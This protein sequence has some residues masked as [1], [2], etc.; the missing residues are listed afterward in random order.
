[1]ESAHWRP[2]KD[3]DLEDANKYFERTK[4]CNITNLG[5]LVDSI[6]ISQNFV[7]V[8]RCVIDSE[9]AE[10][11]VSARVIQAVSYARESSAQ[12]CVNHHREARTSIREIRGANGDPQVAQR[13]AL[14]SERVFKVLLV[15]GGVGHLYARL[16]TENG[17]LNEFLRTLRSYIAA[18]AESAFEGVSKLVNNRKCNGLME[19]PNP[20]IC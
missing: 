19:L 18:A 12:V 2:G 10:R 7:Q 16:S 3:V 5:I 9:R 11:R 4:T 6:D 15:H 17:T 14:R 20:I 13:G 1:M 8:R